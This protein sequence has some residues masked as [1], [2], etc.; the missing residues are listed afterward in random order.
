MTLYFA[1]EVFSQCTT[2]S[3]CMALQRDLWPGMEEIK[4][5]FCRDKSHETEH[6]LQDSYA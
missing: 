3:L 5:I 4:S 2:K 1:A 6:K